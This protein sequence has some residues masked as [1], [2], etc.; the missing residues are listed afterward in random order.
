MSCNHA[1]ALLLA[2]TMTVACE[3]NP[4]AAENQ[5]AHQG[6]MTDTTAK[7]AIA[8]LPMP[9]FTSA[10]GTPPSVPAPSLVAAAQVAPPPSKTLDA[11]ITAAEQHAIAVLPAD[12]GHAIA[13]GG[14]LICH[15]AAMFEQQHKDSTA[16]NKTVTQMIAWGA[17]VTAGQK[18]ILVMY[19]ATHFGP[20][21]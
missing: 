20:A 7:T 10:Q 18:P 19:L 13:L 12:S 11:S 6:E 14:C 1:S 4:R 8:Y 2:L 5:T 21:H 9:G 17:P 3:R 16:W 15:S